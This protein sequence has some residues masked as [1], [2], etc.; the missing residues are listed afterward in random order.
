MKW[1]KK[2]QEAISMGIFQ[3]WDELLKRDRSKQEEKSFWEQYFLKEKEIYQEILQNKEFEIQTTVDAFAKK[4]D[5]E[6][7][8]AVGF[9]DGINTSLKEP[10]QLEDLK[11]EDV[12]TL[13]ILPEELYL[14][15]HEAGANW[16]YELTEWEDILSKDQR[17]DIE[18]AYKKSK[19]FVTD[20]IVGRNDLC[21][22]G[23]GKKYKKC[24]GKKN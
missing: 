13:H 7:L 23:S 20:T 1:I 17:N 9:I 21:L 8:W 14:H 11:Q 19:T 5:T 24:C 18:V 16:L 12:I 2:I 15:M 3:E 22:C 4:Y 10:V 6:I